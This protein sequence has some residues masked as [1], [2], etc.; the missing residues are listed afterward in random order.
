MIRASAPGSVC[1]VGDLT[2]RHGGT[3]LACSTRERAHCILDN[4][5]LIDD[6]SIEAG[7]EKQQVRD[8]ADLALCSDNLDPLRAVLSALEVLSAGAAPFCLKA[9]TSI[10]SYAVLG[11]RSAELASIVGCVLSHMG[12]LLNPYEVAELVRRIECDL[13]SA[14]CGFR[15]HYMA[16]FG[17]LCAI[18]FRDKGGAQP[19]EDA[20]FAA[21]EALHAFVGEPPLLVAVAPEPHFAVREQEAHRPAAASSVHVESGRLARLAKKA[22]LAKDWETVGALMNHDNSLHAVSAGGSDALA[23]AALRAG[24]LGAHAVG[25]GE[26]VVV[27]APSRERVAQALVDAGAQA[28]LQPVPTKGLTVEIAT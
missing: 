12:L 10:P 4:S 7:D 23:Q 20:P 8:S 13:T 19:Q 25:H 16:A 21:V 6:I 22:L 14:S 27:L 2:D 17:G 15:D 5:P 3:V 9:S 28:I 24:A 11:G 26:A 18:D 1:L